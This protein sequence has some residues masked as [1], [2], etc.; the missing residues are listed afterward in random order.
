[1]NSIS[2]SASAASRRCPRGQGGAGAHAGESAR[3]WRAARGA[4]LRYV[5]QA[6]DRGGLQLGCGHHA[7]SGWLA[8]DLDPR[9]ARGAIHLDVTER[10]PFPDGA[11]ERVHSEHLIEHVSLAS[12]RAMLGE[13]ARVLVRGGRIR[14]AT[15][16]LAR[17]AGLVANRGDSREGE[18]YVAWIPAAFP[19]AGLEA[20][21]A[22]VLNHAMRAWGHVFLYDEPT[23]RA[24]LERAGFRDVRR[25]P[26]NQ[27]DDPGMSG[28]T[29]ALTVG[30][31]AERGGRPWCWRP[32]GA[33]VSITLTGAGTG[34]R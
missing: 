7:P 9:L 5:A 29:H 24:E 16:D 13:C 34:P 30:R 25:H 28:E 21:P 11:F 23:L 15:P 17:L 33:D 8:T 6:T 27:S 4:I 10:F 31:R 32:S 18:A 12:G 19:S 22:D 1:M 26:M 3:Y 14:I 2:S 20:R